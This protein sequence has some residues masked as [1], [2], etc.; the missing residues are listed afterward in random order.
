ML[1]TQKER[2]TE[3][4]KER[5]RERNKRAAAA[6][7]CHFYTKMFVKMCNRGSKEGRGD[8]W[9]GKYTKLRSLLL[10]QKVKWKKQG[11]H[12]ISICATHHHHQHRPIAFTKAVMDERIEEG[13][14]EFCVRS[15]SQV[16]ILF[17]SLSLFIFIL[18]NNMLLSDEAKRYN[19][20][21][22]SVVS[23]PV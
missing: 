13:E 7:R 22:K 9:R 1:S 17:S 23:L 19:W 15:C 2:R 4:K 18:F 8:E 11:F 3:R 6:T 5:K 14:A 12:F 10:F 20:V 16:F 21:T